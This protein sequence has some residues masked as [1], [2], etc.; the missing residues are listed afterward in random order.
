MHIRDVIQSLFFFDL[1]LRVHSDTGVPE[2]ERDNSSLA[3]MYDP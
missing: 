1:L 2:I 3:S